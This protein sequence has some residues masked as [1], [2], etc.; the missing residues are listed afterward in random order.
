MHEDASL[1]IDHGIA[2][3]LGSCAFVNT[4]ARN[5]LRVIGR[6]QDLARVYPRIVIGGV[7]VI[8]DF[9]FVP[10]VVAGGQ[11]VATQVKDFVGDRGSQPEAASGIFRVG[12]H[13]INF[14]GLHNVGK[15]VADNLAPGTTENIADK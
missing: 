3:S 9:T 15:M 5:A 2:L 11:Y 7:E 8:H 4:H 12:N 14:V 1:Q 6:A 10:D 13:Q